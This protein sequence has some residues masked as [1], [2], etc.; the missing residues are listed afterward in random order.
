MAG[1]LRVTDAASAAAMPI[2]RVALRLML[3]TRGYLLDRFNA[4]INISGGVKNG[5]DARTR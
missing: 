1:L 3:R 4:V 2:V 5:L